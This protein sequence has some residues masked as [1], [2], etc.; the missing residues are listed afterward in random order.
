[1]LG[2]SLEFISSHM[3]NSNFIYL[4]LKTKITYNVSDYK[5]YASPKHTIDS[6][7]LLNTYIPLLCHVYFEGSGL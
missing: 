3:C 7:R 1:M 2:H 4:I 6:T 5:E